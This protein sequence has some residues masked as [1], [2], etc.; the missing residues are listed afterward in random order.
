M[1][2]PARKTIAE[3]RKL[4]KDT[5]FST[6]GVVMASAQRREKK[7]KGNPYWTITLMDE[8]STVEGLVWSNGVWKDVRDGGSTDVDPLTSDL[9]KGLNGRSLELRGKVSEYKG[10]IQYIFNIVSFVDQEKYPP[11]QFVQKSPIP[12]ETLLKGLD[13]ILGQCGELEEFVRRILESDGIRRNFESF[14][15]AVSHHHAYTAGLLEHTISVA[16]AAVAMADAS[17][18]SGYPVDRGIVAAGA[19][20]HD[21]GK[22]DA[23]R[24]SPMPQMTV[25]GTVIDHV[26]LG[27]A[28]FDRLAEEFGLEE[29]LR[30][31]LGHIL[32]SHHGSKEFGSPALPA[33]P[34]AMIVSSAD[35]LDFRLYCWKNAVDQLDDDSDGITDFSYSAGRR[36][37]KWRE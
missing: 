37:W 22:L 18:A 20:L 11:H 27:Y 26:A 14:P 25:P 12:V 28:R 34:E 7:G 1:T 9:A 30:L 21:L 32:I 10:K 2:E 15:A 5:E 31:A 19:L 35:E 24:L 3:V 23:Y 16:R 17:A 13:E 8:T 6:I 36:F 4:S 29:R 33:T